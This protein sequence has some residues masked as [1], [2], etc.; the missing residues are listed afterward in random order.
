MLETFVSLIDQQNNKWAA[1]WQNQQ[2]E[3]APSKNSDQP[4]HPPSLISL[5]CVLL[6]WVAK[7]LSF[8]FGDSEDSDRTGRT[9]ILLV[10]SC[11][12][13]NI[14]SVSILVND[15]YYFSQGSLWNSCTAVLQILSGVLYILSSSLFTS[16]LVILL[17]QFCPENRIYK[18]R[19]FL[20]VDLQESL[21]QDFSPSRKIKLLFRILLFFICRPIMF[22]G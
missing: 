11:C 16:F 14:A 1:S 9:A 22:L 18:A 2:N 13:S 17:K 12:G 7:D 21:P 10:L 19:F 4:W 20:F 5:R 8:L 15:Q 3:S 6:K